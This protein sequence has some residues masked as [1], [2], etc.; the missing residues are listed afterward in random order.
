MARQP[1]PFHPGF[2]LPPA[3]LAGR[4]RVIEDFVE[5]LDIAALDHRT[6]RTMILVGP[7][8][9]GKTVTL[10]ELAEV[11]GK[12]LSW[13]T[14]HVEAKPSTFLRDLVTRMAEVTELL[15][16]EAAPRPDR[17]RR[18]PRI[19]GG[20]ISAAGFGVGAELHLVNAGDIPPSPIEQL[21]EVFARA[22]EAAIERDAGI[23]LTLDELQTAKPEDVATLAAVLQEHVPH[24]WPLVVVIAALPSLRT[25]RG[26]KAL[27]TYLERAQWHDL[28][29]LDEAAT[30]TALTEPASMAGRPM[31]PESAAALT[32][33]SGG[34]PYAIQVCG[35]FAW[36][37][38]TGSDTITAEHAELARPRIEADLDQ[39]FRSRWEDASPN[40]REYLI[41]MARAAA[42]RAPTSRAVADE[43]ATTTPRV[44]Y[45]RDRLLKKGTIYA[46][47]DGTMHFI[48]P[49]MGEWLLRHQ[50]SG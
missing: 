34:Y 15:E 33:L 8:G 48:T 17:R 12:R 9:V 23:V 2:N 3:V 11:A 19:A 24:D 26:P 41:A 38:S 46:T 27:P 40:E 35:H 36:R 18:Q 43:L 28:G 29:P 39:L 13:P 4:A 47:G 21:D 5:A 45:L 10:G 50:D 7:R 6:P 1:N 49:G 37:A 25:T 14:V 42:D 32:A 20:K 44:A 31:T 30:H 22:A 16:L